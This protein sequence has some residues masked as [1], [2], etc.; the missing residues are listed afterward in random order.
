MQF[1]Q[2]LAVGFRFRRPICEQLRAVII[3]VLREF[4]DN[5]GFARWLKL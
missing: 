2:C 3:Q 1:G 4:F 5:G